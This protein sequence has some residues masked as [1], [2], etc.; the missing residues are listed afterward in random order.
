[1]TAAGV[2]LLVG[3]GNYGAGYARHRHNVGFMVLDAIA[4]HYNATSWQDKFYSHTA[5]LTIDGQKALLLKPQT[6]M[7]LSGKAVLAACQFYKLSAADV[8]VFH[9]DIDLELGKCRLKVGGGHGGHNGLRDIDKA[10]TP[11]YKRVR[12]GVGHPQDKA[13]VHAHVLSNFTDSE[14]HWI[15]TLASNLCQTLPE[16]L[17]GADDKVM[18]AAALAWQQHR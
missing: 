1:M 6:Y 9:D 4:R 3:L 15:T 8:I 2:T 13:L 18:N 5:A 12:I 14:Q 10:I 16:L 17:Q 11:A 7:N